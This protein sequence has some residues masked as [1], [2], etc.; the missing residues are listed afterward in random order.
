MGAPYRCGTDTRRRTVA[1]S[2][3]RVDGIGLNGIDYLEVMDR[4]ATEAHLRQRI[5]HLFFLKPDGIAGFDRTNFRIDGGTRVTDVQVVDVQALAASERGLELTLDRY[6]DFGRYELAVVDASGGTPPFIDPPLARV[7]FSFKTDCPTGFDCAVDEA[8]PDEPPASPAFDLLAKDFWS[9]R[10]LMLDRM[11]ETLPAWTERHDADLGVTLVELLAD[12]ADRLSYFQDAAGTEA[13]LGTARKRLSVR[14]HARLTGYRLNEGTNARTVVALEVESDLHAQDDDGAPL[15]V[16]PAGTRLLTTLARPPVIAAAEEPAAL[17]EDPLVFETLH[18]LESLEVARNGLAFHNWG[19]RDCCLPRGGVR[20]FLV[21]PTPTSTLGAGDMLVLEEGPTADGA[22]AAPTRRHAVRLT[23]DA[24]VLRDHVAGIDVLEVAWHEADA[25]PF[26]MRTD[27]AVA[28]AN[29]VLADEGRTIDDAPAPLDPPAPAVDRPW[30]PVLAEPRGLVHAARFDADRLEARAVAGAMRQSPGDALPAIRLEAAGETWLP[31][32]DLLSLD[33]FAPAFVVETETEERPRL[34]FGEGVFGRRPTGAFGTV[35]WRRGGGPRGNIGADALA[36]LVVPA[37]PLAATLVE[38]YR[39]GRYAFADE[40]AARVTAASIAAA[41]GSAVGTVRNPLPG[42]GGLAPEPV[43]EAKLHAPQAFKVNDRAVTPQDYARLA[44]RHPEVQRATARRRWMGSWHVVFLTVDRRD[45][46]PVDAAFKADLA[47][48][49]ER[50]RLAGHDLEVATPRLVPLDVALWV[51]VARGFVR[52]DV[53]RAILDRLTSDV[54]AD[55]T[56]GY[57]H[58]DRFTFG[59]G[60]ALSSIVAEIMALEGVRWV[61][62]ERPGGGDGEPGHFRK[63]R[64]PLTDYADAGRI[65]IGDF[66]IAI[67]DNAVDRPEDGRLR[68]HMEGG[69]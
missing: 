3:V 1:A 56:L 68:L 43:R 62:I 36:H 16:L 26:A 9:F 66:E 48:F 8:C 21:R 6:G 40:T 32:P 29:V 55:G 11:A 20:A 42:V 59:E 17:G 31:V 53:E 47:R 44:E 67:L 46:R 7:A 45:R 39:A 5:V 22:P 60:V 10:R 35:V 52:A 49:L 58:P 61:G 12:A 27:A 2:T 57:F 15:P 4:G 23:H 64:E 13:Y 69:L 65:P 18:Q 38:G 50:Y 41:V 28:R 25:L 24:T 54:R 37:A 33:G 19:E 34:R 30:R 51:C 63:L 14:R